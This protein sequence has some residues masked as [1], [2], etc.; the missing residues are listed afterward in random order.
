MFQSNHYH[1]I[2]TESDKSGRANLRFSLA[3]C[4][5]NFTLYERG[6]A[7]FMVVTLC[8]LKIERETGVAMQTQLRHRHKRHAIHFQVC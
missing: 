6:K 2:I 1:V 8:K 3:C 4:C 5:R 7:L